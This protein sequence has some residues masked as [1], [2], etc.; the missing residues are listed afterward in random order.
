MDSLKQLLQ[1]YKWWPLLPYETRQYFAFSS[2]PLS[3][4]KSLSLTIHLFMNLIK[5]MMV[6]GK[7]SVPG[8]PANL[9]N[10]LLPDRLF[11]FVRSIF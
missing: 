10:R 6:L 8:R 7:L 2:S 5:L 3:F 1:V 4:S 11:F 9:D